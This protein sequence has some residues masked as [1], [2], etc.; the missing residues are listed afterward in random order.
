MLLSSN[1]GSLVSGT[2]ELISCAF[3]VFALIFT[4]YFWLMDHLS[5]DRNEFAKS[6]PELLSILKKAIAS[7]DDLHAGSDH[8]DLI[9][10]ILNINQQLEIILAYRFWAYSRRKGE[11]KKIQAFMRDSKYLISDIRRSREYTASGES[12]FAI[13]PLGEEEIEAIKQN[14]RE[15]LFYI[16]DFVDNDF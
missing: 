9:D 5:G 15:G 16:L 13:A 6:K 3:T 1:A 8:Q 10:M 4:L 7:L 2:L 11:Y 14:Y 12:I